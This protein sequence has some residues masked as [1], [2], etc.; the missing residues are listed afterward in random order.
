VTLEVPPHHLASSVRELRGMLDR[1][2]T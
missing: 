2:D 1:L